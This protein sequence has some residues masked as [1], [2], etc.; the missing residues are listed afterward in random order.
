MVLYAVVR[1]RGTVKARQK[2]IDT[3]KLLRLNRKM[4]CVLIPDT[5]S[6]KGMLQAAKDYITWGEISEEIL[7]TLIEKRGRRPGNSKLAKEE[8]GS[9]V[10]SILDG[11]R[12]VDVGIKPVFRLSPPKKGFKGSIKQH[13]PRGELGYRGKEINKLLKR[14][15]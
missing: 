5:K 8:A 11:K 7:K 14:M 1:L 13:W 15:I 6:Y 4:H 2:V 12:P 9:V 10:R 3:L